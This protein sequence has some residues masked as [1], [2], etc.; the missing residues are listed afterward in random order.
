MMETD[1]APNDTDD[2]V[3]HLPE[4]TCIVSRVKG[5]PETL[6]RFVAGPNGELVPDL[7]AKLPGRGVW[8]TLDRDMV[9]Q[10]VRKRLFAR[11]LKRQVEV[12]PDLAGQIE[13]RLRQDLL[14]ALAL[15]NKAGCVT[16][17]F[18]RVEAALGPK[19]AA[20]IHAS[21]GAEDGLRKISQAL[22]RA[23]PDDAGTVPI[24]R[25]FTEAE[26][27]L[28][29]GGSLVIHAALVAGPGSEGFMLRWRRLARYRR[30]AY[31]E[32]ST[33]RDM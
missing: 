25:E 16:Y 17:G 32:T 30:E 2:D 18:A 33:T 7:K 3:A 4:R 19:L 26:L 1:P 24:I 14:Q 9:A 11:A 21:D 8:V 10:A 27:G 5:T 20:L 29:L 31:D 15:A 6:I 13:E 23:R 28:A 22:K 12:A